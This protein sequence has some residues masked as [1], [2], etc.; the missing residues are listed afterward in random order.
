MEFR[1]GLVVP[2]APA[3]PERGEAGPL[4]TIMKFPKA[5]DSSRA[6]PQQLHTHARDLVYLGPHSTN[7]NLVILVARH[8]Q[9]VGWRQRWAM[10]CGDGVLGEGEE[11]AR[12]APVVQNAKLSCRLGV[13]NSTMKYLALCTVAISLIGVA[14]A[15]TYTFYNDMTCSTPTAAASGSPNPVVIS[16][17]GC[18]KITGTSSQYQKISSCT[19]NGKMS[20]ALFTDS[21]CSNKISGSDEEIDVNK[22]IPDLIE[23][24]SKK[25]TCDSA[26]SVSLA[27][28]TVIAATV[29]LL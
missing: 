26:S 6:F 11:N 19:P 28:L 5:P 23:R 25:A 4:V 27:F 13:E 7:L 24:N 1:N 8:H 12:G 18:L 17:N 15:V 22:C 10:A 20:V 3:S 2:N 14:S 9:H 16:L 29:A 21:A